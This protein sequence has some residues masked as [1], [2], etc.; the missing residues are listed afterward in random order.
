MFL[1]GCFWNWI[2]KISIIIYILAKKVKQG[3]YVLI[4]SMKEISFKKNLVKRII[5]NIEIERLFYCIYFSFKIRKSTLL[6]TCV[7]TSNQ[8]EVFIKTKLFYSF[9]IKFSFFWKMKCSNICQ[10]IYQNEIH[11][12]IHSIYIYWSKRSF[13]P[14][15]T[16]ILFIRPNRSQFHP[17]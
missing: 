3:K 9:F 11:G 5:I 16:P 13:H 15:K 7:L 14:Y 10:T 4:K 8:E 6:F 17:P 1:V 2:W 12:K